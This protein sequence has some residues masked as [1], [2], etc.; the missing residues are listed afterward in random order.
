MT[1]PQELVQLDNFQDIFQ[2][3]GKI[4]VVTGGSRGLGLQ[5]ASG[6]LQAGCSKVYLVA[7]TAGDLTAAAD[8][9]NGLSAPSR[10][11]DFKAIP[12]VADIST[13]SGCIQMAEEIAKTTDHIDILIANAGATFIGKFDDY[14]ADD[15]ANVMNVNVNSVF[16]STQKL[17]PLLEAGGTVQDPSRVIMVSSVAGVVIGDVGDHGTYAYA[18]SKAAVVH[19]MHNLAVELGPRHITVNVVAP[20]I[21][22]T[23]MSGPLMARHGG[24]EAVAKQ[25][26][27]QKLGSKEDVAGTMVFLSSRAARH[28]NGATIVL[29]GGSFLVRGCA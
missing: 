6:F 29:D 24:L 27:D 26:P 14:K 13:Y 20:G 7:R 3:K 28:I 8:A 1:S 12:I 2:L 19:L 10:A 9:L 11:A 17:T 21:I 15:F 23:K 4:A 18:A 5:T 22:P 25:V 16:F